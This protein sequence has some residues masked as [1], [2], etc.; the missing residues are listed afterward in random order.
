MF[1]YSF[2]IGI[3]LKECWMFHAHKLSSE[4]VFDILNISSYFN[5]F[6][7]F[8]LWNFLFSNI[9]KLVQILFKLIWISGSNMYSVLCKV[10]LLHAWICQVCI[11]S[12]NLLIPVLGTRNYR[13]K[14]MFLR[15][16]SNYVFQSSKCSEINSAVVSL[17][18]RAQILLYLIMISRRW[19][20]QKLRIIVELK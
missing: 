16:S 18:P 11:Y 2:S 20:I 12:W 13:L 14:F 10:I 19:N 15:H 5:N 6:K 4:K 17:I 8:I 9:N 1:S 7:Y 3:Y